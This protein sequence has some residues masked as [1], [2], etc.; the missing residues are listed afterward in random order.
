KELS[1]GPIF[2]NDNPYVA[3]GVYIDFEKVLP[4]IDKEKYEIIGLTY[5]NI[6]KEKLFDDIK[7]NDTEDDWTYYV[8]NDELKGDVDYFIEYN[9]YFDQKFQEYNIKTYDVS[10]NRNL[11]FEKILKISK[12]NNLQT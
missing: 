12:T 9:K 7:S 3:E 8:D 2:Y 10:E 11:V 5:N 1:E 4:S 6:T